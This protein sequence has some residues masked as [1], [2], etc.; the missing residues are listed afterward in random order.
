MNRSNN[1]TQHC[2]L[3]TSFCLLKY[4]FP[5]TVR[6]V[7][8]ERRHILHSMSR[9]A[10]YLPP[11][12]CLTTKPSENIEFVGHSYPHFSQVRQELARVLCDY[13]S[14]PA[15]MVALDEYEAVHTSDYLD[16]LT[17]MAEGTIQERLPRLSVECTG[18][19]FCLPGYQYGLGGMYEVIDHLKAGRIERAYCFS[20]PGHHAHADWGHGYC[21]LN[22]QAC[23][24]RY[25]Q[26]QGFQKVLIVDWDIHHGDGTQDIFACDPSVYCVSIHSLGDLYMTLQ[27]ILRESTTTQGAELGHC[28]IPLLNHVFDDNFFAAM[29]LTGRYYRAHESL[30]AFHAALEQLPWSPDIIFIFSGYDSHKDDCGA[31]ITDWDYADYQTLTRCVL[32]VARLSNCPVLSVHGGGYKLPVTIAA[33]VSHVEVLAEYK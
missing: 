23:A 25:A 4:I 22:P 26:R 10:V 27:G 17:S 15:R 7:Q 11:Q 31:G 21:I 20:L 28:N 33:T 3:P 16:S 18:L 30:A 5:A 2:M 14:L 1:L 12:T 6:V 8:I 13:V 32:D 19:Q 9:F 29:N 24:A